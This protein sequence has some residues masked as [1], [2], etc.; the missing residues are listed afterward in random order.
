MRDEIFDA[1]LHHLS[2]NHI[3]VVDY[4]IK[5]PKFYEELG[6]YVLLGDISDS[7]GHCFLLLWNRFCI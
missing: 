6:M 4:S 2:I 3:Q 5:N 1:Y 7:F